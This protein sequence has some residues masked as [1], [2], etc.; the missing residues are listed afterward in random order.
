LSATKAEKG[1]RYLRSSER[2]EVA[3]VERGERKACSGR[4]KSE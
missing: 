1:E 2:E 4:E 3:A